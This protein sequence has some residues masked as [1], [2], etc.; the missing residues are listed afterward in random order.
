MSSDA[1]TRGP[2]P[3]CAGSQEVTFLF[4]CCPILEKEFI[5]IYE[6]CRRPSIVAQCRAPRAFPWRH[7]AMQVIVEI[8]G[9]LVRSYCKISSRKI[10]EM[11]FRGRLEVMGST[12]LGICARDSLNR[13]YGNATALTFGAPKHLGFVSRTRKFSDF[14]K[15]KYFLRQCKFRQLGVF[16]VFGMPYSARSFLN[17]SR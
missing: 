10:R 16:R 15:G 8:W 4:R 5:R 9:T 6:T 14:G 2:M 13:R 12:L 11:L 1:K 3:P 17:R 7:T